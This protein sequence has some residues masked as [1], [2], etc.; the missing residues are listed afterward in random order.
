VSTITKESSFEGA[1]YLARMIKNTISCLC[2]IMLY[3]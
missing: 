3:N 2:F 1:S